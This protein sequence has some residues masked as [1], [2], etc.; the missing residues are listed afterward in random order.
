[1]EFSAINNVTLYTPVLVP[2][3]YP[4]YVP[5]VNAF[6]QTI[7]VPIAPAPN[8]LVP[9][10]APPPSNM[11]P[12]PPVP[13]MPNVVIPPHCVYDTV[14][15]QDFDRSPSR[16]PSIDASS[17]SGSS[18]VPEVPGYVSN[19]PDTRTPPLPQLSEEMTKRQIVASTLDWLSQTFQDQFDT[20][21]NRGELVLRMKIKT[22]EA[23]D[24][25]CPFVTL[26]VKESLLCKMSCPISTKNGRKHIR[27]YLAYMEAVSEEAAERVIELY[28]EFNK[29]H[30]LPNG[31]PVFSG[32][33]LNPSSVRPKR[34]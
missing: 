30:V 16:S 17:D 15:G 2:V 20:I 31:E 3:N 14:C 21:G 8:T 25:F 9:I 12:F 33:Q 26:C 24:A 1:M 29:T 7:M 19:T 11:L 22:R 28:N 4:S 5:A 6:G 18:G 10:M 27:G 13:M 34:S 23:L 32:L